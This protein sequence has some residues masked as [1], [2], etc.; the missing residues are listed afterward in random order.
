[1]KVEL[2]A[3][4]TINGQVVLAKHSNLYEAPQEISGMGISKAIECG[5]LVVGR[6]TYEM[7]LPIMKDL[8]SSLEVVVLSSA[9]ID[10]AHTEKSVKNVLEYL[11]NKGYSKTCVI[12]GTETYNSFLESGLVD[13]LY[14]NLFPIILNDGGLLQISFDKNNGYTLQE[15][16][17][18]SDIVSLHYQKK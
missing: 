5:T 14:L 18:I 10:G 16:T 6:T 9:K 17:S 4:L 8:F 12:G 13:D 11:S 15:V 3:N 1:M 2:V 7:F